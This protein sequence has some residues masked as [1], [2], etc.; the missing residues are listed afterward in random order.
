MKHTK[1][2]NARA[3]DIV[4]SI[5]S[6]HPRFF[7]LRLSLFSS[8]QSQPHAYDARQCAARP[9]EPGLKGAPWPFPL[10]SD[11]ADDAAAFDFFD[12]D[13]RRRA[14]FKMAPQETLA[15]APSAQQE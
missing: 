5:V 12:L 14:H 11:S 10:A 13:C 8:G 15:V 6:S 3:F 2:K 9:L 4:A 1:I 7:R